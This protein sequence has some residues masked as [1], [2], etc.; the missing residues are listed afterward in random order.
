M[1][2]DAYESD[3]SDDAYELRK[4]RCR[5]LWRKEFNKEHEVLNA[6]FRLEAA[7]KIGHPILLGPIEDGSWDLYSTG[8][9]NNCPTGSR[10]NKSIAF[11][12]FWGTRPEFCCDAYQVVASISIYP[13][14]RLKVYPLTI[15]RYAH[16]QPVILDSE[17]GHNTSVI[18]LGGGYLKLIVDMYI[19]NG[20]EPTPRAVS[21]TPKEVVEISGI[22]RSREDK[23]RIKEED[24]RQFPKFNV[25]V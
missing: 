21:E 12:H 19:I 18:F 1:D 20:T 14:A 3:E 15:P 23:D 17:E 5:R 2:V 6:L 7:V 25:R 9:L 22:F 10:S 13:A 4:Q 8:Y 11:G 24:S 16:I